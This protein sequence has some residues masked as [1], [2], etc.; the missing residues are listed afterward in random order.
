[1]LKKLKNLMHLKKNEKNSNN[2][3]FY[4]LLFKEQFKSL[5]NILGL[6]LK[7]T[8]ENLLKLKK[9]I[10]VPIQMSYNKLKKLQKVGLFLYVII[11]IYRGI[12]FDPCFFLGILLLPFYLFLLQQRRVKGF[13]RMRQRDTRVRLKHYYND[14]Y[15][16][17][18][19]VNTSFIFIAICGL[20]M[21]NFEF[22]KN[23]LSTLG[24]F[25]PISLGQFQKY[26]FF[27]FLFVVGV[28]WLTNIYIIWCKNTRPFFKTLASQE[29]TIGAGITTYLGIQSFV[30]LSDPE[31]NPTLHYYYHSYDPLG[32]R[33]HFH[34]GRHIEQS[35]WVKGALG[36][37]Y[38]PKLF[39]DE[40][41]YFDRQRFLGFV[42]SNR[43]E[44]G[45]EISDEQKAGFP[46]W[47]KWAPETNMSR[48]D[49]TILKDSSG[50]VI[51]HMRY[52]TKGQLVPQFL[53]GLALEPLYRPANF[54]APDS[55]DKEFTISGTALNSSVDSKKGVPII[56]PVA[57]QESSESSSSI[58]SVGEIIVPSSKPRTK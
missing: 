26:T 36:S 5:I 40:N 41:N 8:S 57:S 48:G 44:I 3:V 58:T 28:N 37:R 43:F 16:V 45:G 2:K 53:P 12:F 54:T 38:N 49:P 9:L 24:V 34:T 4:T 20:I 7:P 55:F 27:Y 46:S 32:R 1:M 25:F 50:V 42:W 6:I 52:N 22:T 19:F 14:F 56:S 51:G 17:W 47:I 11:T 10:I 13:I 21:Y 29:V 31:V 23:Y 15:Y 35:N 30:N 18:V 39:L 33:Y